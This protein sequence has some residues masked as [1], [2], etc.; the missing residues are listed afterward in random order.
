MEQGR[1]RRTLV[2][3]RIAIIVEGATEAGFKAALLDFLAG[4]LAVGQAP[5]LQFISSDGRIPKGD[6]LK[7]DV[8]RLL[9]ANDA[10]IALTDVYTGT[11]PH[12]FETAA[13]AKTKMRQ[14]VGQEPRFCP[15]A[16]QHDF[17]AW[18]LPYWPRVKTLADSNRRAPS[19]HP[20]TVNHQ[21]PPS[22]H[23][24][25]VFRTGG[26]KRIYSKIRDGAAILREQDLTVSAAACPELK[27]F[28]NTILKLCGG[29]PL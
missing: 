10:V 19:Q 26:K 22:K 28:L 27:D 24:A 14:W 8:E 3:V 4:R 18:L 17:E 6:L 12:D 29:P 7:R 11:E 5:K 23:L 2:T 1:S 25:E 21:K 16:A 15:H 13:D 20:E 9:K